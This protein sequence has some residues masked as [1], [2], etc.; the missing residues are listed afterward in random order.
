MAQGE[1]LPLAV[2]MLP[3]EH[4]ARLPAE[5]ADLF[6]SGEHES[7]DLSAEWFRL[8]GSAAMATGVEPRY[9]VLKRGDEV[10]GFLPLAVQRSRRARRVGSLTNFYTSLYRPLLAP[11]VNAEELAAYLRN[12]HEQ[13]HAD[14][15]RFDAM[16][17]AHP[18]FGV[19]ESALRRAGLRTFRFFGFG[20]WYLPVEGRSFEE[21]F[22][23]LSSQVRN[24]VRRRE[25]KFLADGRGA[26]RIVAGG[27]A[28][29][30]AIAAWEKIY[31]VSWKTAEP[32]TEFL[33]GLIRMCAARGWLR[34]GLAYYDGEAV[35]AQLWI[36][37]HGR[38]AIYKLA[39]DEKFAQLSAGTV[40]TANLMR[41]VLDVDKVREVDYLIGDDGYK[42]DWMKHRRERWGVLAFNLRTPAGLFGA[43]NESARRMVKQMIA[44][45]RAMQTRIRTEK[46]LD[47]AV[48]RDSK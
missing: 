18:A 39:Y 17:P 26:L 3:P 23:G 43:I 46:R 38:A 40:L 36:V 2:D 16:D 13:T 37:S 15:V 8:L 24:T 45:I 35:A 44:G 27:D 11:S 25:K 9:Y 4:L 7:F 29:E 33:P 48:V 6:L 28:L 31:R 1:L 42:K 41:H 12:I 34:L 47:A 19:L 5:C 22:Q 21:Y 20:N 32:F 30:E 14:V 10:R